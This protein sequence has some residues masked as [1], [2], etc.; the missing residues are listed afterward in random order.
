VKNKYA[1]KSELLKRYI[2]AIWDTMEWFSALDL[3]SV[4]REHSNLADK[5]AV[6]TS[7]LQPSD[8]LLNSQGKMEINFR[9][10]VP[11]NIDHWHVFRDDKQ[12]L[13]FVHN[14]Q[15]FSDFNVSYKEEGHEY[16]EE[17]DPIKNPV[18]RGLVALEQIFDRMTCM[19]RKKK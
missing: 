2:N 5:L 8:E 10:L 18:P 12:I 13:N 15:E 11:D 3:I 16:V 9:P 6:S 4:P 7:T 19:K 17:D 14:V 1:C